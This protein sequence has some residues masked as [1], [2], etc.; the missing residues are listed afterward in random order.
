MSLISFENSVPFSY[1][2]DDY[3]TLCDLCGKR[4]EIFYMQSNVVWTYAI[5]KS[6]VQQIE[7]MFE[8]LNNPLPYL[9]HL[10][11]TDYIVPHCRK[12][13]HKYAVGHFLAA[14]LAL[15]KLLNVMDIVKL[16]KHIILRI[17]P[18]N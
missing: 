17:V 4:D 18:A 9:S 15:G 11:K 13:A 2:Y 12:S 16:I 14:G 6:C 5:C 10:N 3:D 8:Y 1:E 7:W